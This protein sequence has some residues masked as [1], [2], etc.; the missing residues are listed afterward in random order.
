MKSFI[1]IFAILTVVSCSLSTSMADPDAQVTHQIRIRVEKPPG[2]Y[3]IYGTNARNVKELQG[4]L[5]SHCVFGT[6]KLGYRTQGSE[7]PSYEGDA[8]A[9]SS[10]DDNYFK[11]LIEDSPGELRFVQADQFDQNSKC[12]N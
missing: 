7:E 11:W 4:F 5:Q 6:V 12:R 1:R 2:G 10:L 3:E 8:V 9:V